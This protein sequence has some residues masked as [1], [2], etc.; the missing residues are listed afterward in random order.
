MV[1]GSREE[2]DG[3]G[4]PQP[5]ELNPS[6]RDFQ[7]QRQFNSKNKISKFK[8]RYLLDNNK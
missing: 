2:E 6:Q 1:L 3:L 8:R 5:L 4:S 7:L